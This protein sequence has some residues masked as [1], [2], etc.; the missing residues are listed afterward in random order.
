MTQLTDDFGSHKLE[1]PSKV[2]KL[3]VSEISPKLNVCPHTQVYVL[4]RPRLHGPVY[5]DFVSARVAL[6]EFF[7]L[8]EYFGLV[9]Y[10]VISAKFLIR[11]VVYSAYILNCSVTYK[12]T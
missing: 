3:L 6:G 7:F 9:P 12:P 8:S 11:S 4:Y 2:V 1:E 10:V 5:V